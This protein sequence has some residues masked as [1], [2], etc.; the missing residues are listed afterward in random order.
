MN[1]EISKD[2]VNIKED[3][4]EMK[5]EIFKLNNL[6]IDIIKEL[7]INSDM[8]IKDKDSREIEN[9]LSKCLNDF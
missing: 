7:R 8:K 3:I 2:M 5:E 4:L 6:I 9:I 1:N